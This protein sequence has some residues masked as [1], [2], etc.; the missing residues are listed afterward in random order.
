VFSI[1]VDRTHTV[2]LVEFSDRIQVQDL[3]DL[4]RLVAPVAPTNALQVAVVDLRRVTA[5]DVPLE[6]IIERASAPPALPGRKLVFV[7]GGGAT[8]GLSRQFS[9]LRERAG[10]G[11]ILIVSDLEAAWHELGI[12][13]PTFR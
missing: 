10:H 2:L 8:L 4:N 11:K 5:I 13:A 6:E 9:A 3:T 7:T 1:V 12:A